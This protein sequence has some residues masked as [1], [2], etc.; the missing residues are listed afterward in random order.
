LPQEPEPAGVGAGNK[1]QAA[2]ASKPLAKPE[3]N[4]SSSNPTPQQG[5]GGSGA[6]TTE[7]GATSQPPSS[8]VG[9]AIRPSWRQ[10]QIDVGKALEQRGFRRQVAFKDGAE[11]Q[12]NRNPKDCTRPDFYK[13]GISVDVKNYDVKTSLGRANLI[14]SIADQAKS[15][16]SQLP[17]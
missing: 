3:G 8:E 15:R 9:Q 11:V 5:Q 2:D 6:A 17:P 1:P 4:P 14:R 10:S 12:G 7:P 13:P 16:A